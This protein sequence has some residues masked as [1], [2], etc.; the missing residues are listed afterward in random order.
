MSW[1]LLLLAAC[2]QPHEWPEPDAWGELQGPGGPAVSFTEDELFA[3]CAYLTGG[4]DDEQH[5]NLVV[6]HDGHLLLP[7]A[8]ED[9]GGGITWF[10]F[11]DPCNPT[12]VGEAWADGMR[13][14]HSLAFGRV[15]D[16][17]YLA[18]DY[19]DPADDDLGGIGLWDVTDRTS[20]VWISEIALPDYHYPDAYFR[21][22]L[23]TFWQG[24]LI[25]AP[26]GF[27][28]VYI[29]DASDPEHPE[30]VGHFT[31]SDPGLLAGTF[32]VIG[33]LGMVS[34]AGLPRTVMM[35]VGDPLDPQPLPGG[36]FDVVDSADVPTN[37]YFANV[38]GEWGLFARKQVGG[39][40]IVYDI[41]DPTEPVFLGD[42]HTAE[43]SG[44]YIFRHHDLLFIGDSEFGDIY[45]ATDPGNLQQVGHFELSG[46]LDTVTPIG[47][48]AVVSVDKGA[49]DG[50]STSVV[51]WDTEP[52]STPPT[53]KLV[54][55]FDG[56][57]YQ[58]LTTRIGLSFDELVE[59]KSVFEG[60]FRVAT[61]KGE[62]VSGRFQT[63]ENIVNFTPDEPLLDDMTYIVTIPAGGIVDLSGNPVAEETS[64]AF[65]TGAEVRP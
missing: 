12:K 63:Q 56:D 18:V 47:N 42:L 35:D 53:V 30:E 1:F 4:E 31:W 21:V 19:H 62:P 37:Y 22:T 32:H 36:E 29:I 17:E 43:G 20:P 14:S 9:G 40:P 16:R 39:G 38:G 41:S 50:Q 5:H 7:W 55:P 61:R 34:S 8:P 64:F 33:N 23:S 2:V 57:T 27:N 44:G 6:M 48:V 65:S 58:P 24:D 26:M 28:G 13:E 46:D 60:S 45:D 59:G 11:A 3:D 10:D 49:A 25:Y 51:P 52:D 15:G 54:S